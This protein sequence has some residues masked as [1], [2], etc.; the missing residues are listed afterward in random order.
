MY[1]NFR[2]YTNELA[3]A[4]KISYE[5]DGGWIGDEDDGTGLNIDGGTL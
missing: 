4:G 2:D 5:I 1:E 3:T